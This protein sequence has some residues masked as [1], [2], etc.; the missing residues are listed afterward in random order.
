MTRQ[1]IRTPY[2]FH[3]AGA[4]VQHNPRA[5]VTCCKRHPLPRRS[6]LQRILD[7]VARLCR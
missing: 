5:H 3:V 7:E 1:A 4:Y 2:P 6:M